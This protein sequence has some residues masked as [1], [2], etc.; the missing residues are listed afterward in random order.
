MCTL[1]QR[2]GR[3]ARHFK[4]RGAAILLAEPKYF[5]TVELEDS[6]ITGQK[7]TADGPADDQRPTKRTY[8]AAAGHHPSDVETAKEGLERLEQLRVRYN[9]APMHVESRGGGRG[10]KKKDKG[11]ELVM[12]EFIN[13]ATR[14]HL[15]CFHKPVWIYFGNF[16]LGE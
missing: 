12:D 4:C 16:K 3:A 11:I 9:Q 8:N 6:N 13:A 1:W 7:R 15:C 2:F 5:D 10:A 14:A